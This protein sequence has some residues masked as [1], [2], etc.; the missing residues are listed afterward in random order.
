MPVIPGCK[1]KK[2]AT[3]P[4]DQERWI[5]PVILPTWEAELKKITV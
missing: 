1:K 5:K 2:S 3:I 4:P